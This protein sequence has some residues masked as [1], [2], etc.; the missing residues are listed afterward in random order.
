MFYLLIFLCLLVF[1]SIHVIDYHS[2]R[3]IVDSS[4]QLRKCN[5]LFTLFG[6]KI[7][8]DWPFFVKR[9]DS[10]KFLKVNIK[11]AIINV[12]IVNPSLYW[13]SFRFNIDYVSKQIE[14]KITD[15]YDVNIFKCLMLEELRPEECKKYVISRRCYQNIIVGDVNEYLKKYRC[16]GLKIELDVESTLDKFLAVYKKKIEDIICIHVTRD[17]DLGIITGVIKLD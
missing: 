10:Q 8:F 16:N 17:G 6:K 14:N 1:K 7:I 3:Y 13:S 4:G 12:K 11:N 9:I 5:Y 2:R 15:I